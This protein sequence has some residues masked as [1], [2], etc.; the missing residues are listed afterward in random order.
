MKFA[1][2]LAAFG[3]QK[4]IYLF[5]GLITACTVA[6]GI[7]G[8]LAIT[9]LN[10]S[11]QDAVGSARE[12]AEVAALARLSVINIDR[13][14]A[15]LIAAQA[16]EDLR[17]QAI[18]A[19]R[20]ASY[21]EESLQTL[22][23]VLPGDAK[24]AELVRLNGAVK[25][26]RLLII[27]AAKSHN[28]AAAAEQ[29][30][31]I[32]AP[33]ARIEEV[34]E[35][36][37]AAQQGL[38]AAR[39]AQ[40]EKTGM[41][42]LVVLGVFTLAGV[43][44]A[45]LASAAFVRLL[46]NSIGNVEGGKQALTDNALQVATIAEDITGCDQRTGVAVEQIRVDM[47]E[48][49]AATEQSGEH[50]VAATGRILEMAGTVAENATDVGH[51]AQRFT[52]M[53]ADMQSAIGMTAALAKSVDSISEIADTIDVI[54]RQTNMLAINAAIEA[55]RAG[56]SGRGFAVVAAEVRVLAQRS[57]D[58]TRQIQAIA[59]AIGQQVDGA[60]ATLNRSASNA[61]DYA[62]QL[63]Q[64]VRKS[65]AAAASG[66]QLRGVMESVASQMALQRGAVGAISDQLEAV[67]IATEQ[68]TAQVVALRAVSRGLTDSAGNLGKLADNLRL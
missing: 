68:S 23:K 19:I 28:V 55:A 11:L 26:P 12:R 62:G 1:A 4:K 22:E 29:N 49:Q 54:A 25:T 63:G 43:G 8:A 18:A 37:L 13:A 15:R 17:K 64:V 58:A 36:I 65:D 21:L 41:R 10:H 39:V 45:V 60:V 27:K 42:A 32:A 38:L 61:N 47:D 14:Q 48:V 57:G 59:G 33:L 6:V 3:W 66:A 50:I 2:R 30:G 52:L 31:A 67:R 7:V 24:V 34:S 16:P 9:Y 46:A 53:N 56:D 5:A 44:I 51:V 40:M 20:A 35:Q